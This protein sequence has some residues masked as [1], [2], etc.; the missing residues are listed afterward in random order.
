MT[1]QLTKAVDYGIVQLYFDGTK[2]GEPIDL[3]NDGVIATGAIDLGE[4][5]LTKGEHKLKIEIKGAN[6]KAK[7]AY[8]FAIDYLKLE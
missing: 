7:K 5:Q 6:E 2:L 8:M 1:V 3:Y 4:H